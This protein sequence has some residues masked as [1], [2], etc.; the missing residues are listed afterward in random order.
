MAHVP[1]ICT[2]IRTICN[3][4]VRNQRCG[5]KESFKLQHHIVNYVIGLKPDL[6][7]DL[8]SYRVLR[9]NA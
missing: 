3:L 1:T 9:L 7:I 8:R 2:T 4:S 5:T 6:T